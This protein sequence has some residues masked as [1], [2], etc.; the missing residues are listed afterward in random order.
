[1]NGGGAFQDTSSHNQILLEQLDELIQKEG[2][3]KRPKIVV[4]GVAP[5]GVGASNYAAKLGA[6]D[7]IKE[8]SISPTQSQKRL[9]S[10]QFKNKTN[11]GCKSNIVESESRASI[12][13]EIQYYG[14]DDVPMDQS[15]QN[16]SD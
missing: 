8:E 2:G 11:S 12:E 3:Q 5:T 4:N 15:L 9:K 10:S 6:L 16:G 14:N 7:K 1:M 13:I